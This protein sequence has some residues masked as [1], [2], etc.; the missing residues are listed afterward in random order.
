[1]FDERVDP[2]DCD[3]NAL[4]LASRNDYTEVVNLLLMDETVRV[5]DKK[6][7]ACFCCQREE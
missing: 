5:N 1:M 2:S 4:T 7:H 3:I 6:T